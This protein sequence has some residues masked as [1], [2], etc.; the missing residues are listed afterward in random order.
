MTV[1][2]EGLSNF[3]KHCETVG[4]KSQQLNTRVIEQ[5]ALQAK[6]I[7]LNAARSDVPSLR[8]SHFGRK[9]VRLGV[10]YQAEKA[11][12]ATYG[13]NAARVVR[14]FPPG[15]WGL[16][17][18]GAKEHEI[19]PRRRN[20]RGFLG[21]K[22]GGFAAVGGVPHPA[23]SAKRTWSKGADLAVARGAALFRSTQAREYLN[24]FKG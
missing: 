21:N 22:D 8:L 24:V 9:G 4:R 17:E 3:V 14:P 18:K 23:Q 7:V 15:P 13:Y 20:R 6:T 5:T 10:R 11:A 1:K 2:V 19:R 16:L 12:A